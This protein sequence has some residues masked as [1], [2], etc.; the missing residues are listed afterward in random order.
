MSKDDYLKWLE[1]MKQDGVYY[2]KLK[3]H[4]IDIEIDRRRDTLESNQFESNIMVV[5]AP[6]VGCYYSAE[7][8]D[9]Q[10][11][12]NIGDVVKQG[13]TIGII[14]A[15]KLMNR[16]ESPVSGVVK[17]ILVS[18]GDAVEFDQPMITIE[19]N[20]KDLNC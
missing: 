19:C 1:L 5:R 12:V 9:Q 15:M 2:L 10:V 6:L 18:N 3:S 14:E 7:S 16:I 20:E 13:Q 17:D 11:F 8:P 4:T